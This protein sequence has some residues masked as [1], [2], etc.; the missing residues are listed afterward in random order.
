MS[1]TKYEIKKEITMRKT[2]EVVGMSGSN[3]TAVLNN[4]YPSVKKFVGMI[5]ITSYYIVKNLHHRCKNL[6]NTKAFK[7]H[8]LARHKLINTMK[9]MLSSR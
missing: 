3:R 8:T 1:L 2:N 9:K 4:L 6:K 7:F 5:S